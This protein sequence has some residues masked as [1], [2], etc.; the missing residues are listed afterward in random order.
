MIGG[1]GETE[2]TWASLPLAPER[3]EPQRHSGETM[4]TNFND[5]VKQGYVKMK[6]RK[7]G[8][9]HLPR[10]PRSGIWDVG[11]AQPPA[12][13]RPAIVHCWSLEVSGRR[14]AWHVPVPGSAHC[15][16]RPSPAGWSPCGWASSGGR[17]AGGS[18][19]IVEVVTQAAAGNAGLY[20]S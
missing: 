12:G 3:D 17:W 20:L 5:I 15:G 19:A 9:S 1:A 8:V 14:A 10:G 6:S 18:P 2:A 16:P 11:G 4:A 7:L 13:S